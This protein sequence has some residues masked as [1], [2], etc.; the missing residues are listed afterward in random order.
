MK[1]FLLVLI[2]L[3]AAAGAFAQTY[4]F[5]QFQTGFQAFA[6]DVADSLPFNASIGLN[7]SDA[8]IGQFPH[9]GFGVSV[10]A[11]TIPFDSVDS[12]FAAIGEPTPTEL[13][14]LRPYGLPIP[15]YTAEVRIGGF[16]I[17]FDIGLKGGYIA[18]E[19]L[20]GLISGINVDYL[21]V[22]GDVRFGLLKDQG[23]VPA[24]SVG[25][26]YT[27][28]KGA[29]GMPGI[30]G[31]GPVTV[32]DFTVP[33]GGGG[34]TTYSLGFTD[35]SLDFNWQ[36]NAIDVKAQVSKKL[37]LFTFSAGLGGTYGISQAGGAVK[38]TMTITPT[39]TPAEQALID[40]YLAANGMTMGD[41]GFT[42]TSAANGWALR[43][44][45]GVSMNLLIVRLDLNAMYNF[46]S[47]SYGASVNLRLQF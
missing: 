29:V 20:Q 2:I 40:A 46:L 31:T 10:G 36:T 26:G 44:F 6:D 16:G 13:E 19:W 9:M 43:A 14:P 24:L 45:G 23:W 33:D 25:A 1:R 18:P 42:V 37:L 30:F 27:Y 32:S 21:M 7:W 4:D 12:V 47:G 34:F 41:Q 11:T 38:S 35:P 22:G 3:C 17:P 39:P 15:A 8:Y 5:S 28:M